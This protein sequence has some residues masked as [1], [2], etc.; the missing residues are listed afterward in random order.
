[1]KTTS[2]NIFFIV[3]EIK[4][5]LSHR[6]ALVQA[7]IE[8]GWHF[9]VITSADTPPIPL[10]GISYHIVDTH[11][12]RFSAFN[13]LKNSISLMKLIYNEDPALIYG[14]SHRSIFLAGIVNLLFNKKSIYAISGMGSLFSNDTETKNTYKNIFL[15]FLV[16][17]IYRHMIRSKNSNFLLQNKDDQDFLISSKIALKKNCFLIPGNGLEDSKFDNRIAST[18]PI[19]FIMISRLLRD[20]GVIEFLDA[21]QEVLNSNRECKFILYGD[22]DGANFKS[23]NL[24]D[25][26]PYLSSDI[27][28][29]GFHSNIQECIMNASIVVLPSYREGFSKVL[30]EAQACARPVITSNV[31]GCKDAVVENISGV[32]I[33]PMDSKALE[34]AMN[35]FVDKPHLINEMGQDAY[36]HAQKHFTI[37]KAV[38]SHL[39]MF[40]RIL[41][42]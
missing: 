26:E 37:E 10:K 20:K 7:L 25:I 29:A 38:E 21:A 12:T 14:I 1:M 33:P 5:F 28:Y 24:S 9:T 4:F 8:E 19:I 35:S 18:T 11:R 15:Q 39:R 30:M 13:L 17:W 6:Y 22:I 23:L 42:A 27:E 40:D 31:I 34:D 16:V 3:P 32:L 36:K 2:K 41:S